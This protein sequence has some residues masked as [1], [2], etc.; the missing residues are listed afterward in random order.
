M[1][2]PSPTAPTAP[3]PPPISLQKREF[4]GLAI[5]VRALGLLSILILQYHHNEIDIMHDHAEIQI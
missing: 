1:V 4:K 2:M 5:F 3:V